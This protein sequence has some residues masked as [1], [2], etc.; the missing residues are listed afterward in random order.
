[1][2]RVRSPSPEIYDWNLK[3]IFF[4]TL[5]CQTHLRILFDHRHYDQ[6]YRKKVENIRLQGYFSKNRSFWK[7]V[8]SLETYVKQRQKL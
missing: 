6:Q 3:N 2:E 5:R 8:I 1:M 4:N 7:L